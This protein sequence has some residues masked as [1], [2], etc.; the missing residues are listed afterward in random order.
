VVCRSLK[1]IDKS[2]DEDKDGPPTKVMWY[3]PIVPRFKR[4]FSIKEDA[5]N[6]K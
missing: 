6:L 1:K 5:K 2:G 4:L 3:L